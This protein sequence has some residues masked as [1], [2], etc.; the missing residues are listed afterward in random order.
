M[1]KK[2]LIAVAA[3]S[4][5]FMLVASGCS[6]AAPGPA[7]NGE[8][9]LSFNTGEPKSLVAS[10]DAGSQLAMAMCANLME[11]NVETQ[12]YEP[13]AA[14][15]VT[16]TDA[17][18]WKIQLQDDWTFQD[19]S[20]V[21][22][23]SFVD[24]WNKTATGSN[25]WQGNAYFTVFEGYKELNPTDGSKPT[26][27]KLSGVKVIDDKNFE[28]TLKAPNADFPMLLSANALCPLPKQAFSDPEGYEANPI[29]NGP[30]QFV[31]WDHNVEIVMKKWDGFKGAQG[32]SG[33]A[34]KL[35]GKIYTAIDAA[36]T[37]MVAGNLDMIRA[38]PASMISKGK[39]QLGDDSVYPMSI[40]SAQQTLQFP[41]YVA[42]LKNP[43]LRKAISMSIDREAIAKSLLEGQATA[44]DAL[45]PPSLASYR[46]G[47][48]DSCTFDPVG[49]KKL[50]EKAGGFDGTLYLEFGGTTY[51]QLVQVISKQIQDNLGIKVQMKPMLGTELEARRNGKKLEGAVFGGW[52][53]AYKSPDQFLSQYETGGD[54][55][56]TSGY[57]NPAV[58]KLI[59]DARAVQDPTKAGEVY[60]AAEAEIMKD[61][62]SI[63]LFIPADPGLHS[64][65]A[66]MND[67]QG[68][69]QYYRAGYAC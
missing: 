26:T 34:D 2:N 52:G 21:V 55:N 30:Y 35:V 28:V 58:D 43:D 1:L 6:S 33:G 12:E 47:S 31:S 23:S 44:S 22:A 13:L 27:D 25:A 46:E 40:G 32:F 41:E 37:D 57:S 62:P 17:K 3:A 56:A 51:Q 68:D 36:Y 9:T 67:S 59:K 18:T 69:L 42:E 29:S 50:L 11:V 8:K 20:P 63:P 64:K 5:A 14:K 54:G 60:A 19:G 16:S 15:S 48:C 4:A 66:V 10:K 53:W 38:V 24:A 49:A 7:A 61:M 39:S 45:V 65:C